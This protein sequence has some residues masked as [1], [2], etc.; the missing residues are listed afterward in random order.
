MHQCRKR[1]PHVISRWGVSYL[2]RGLRFSL[3]QAANTS[4]A[5][6]AHLNDQSTDRTLLG[7]PGAAG[8]GYR[9][10][11]P[12]PGT[13]RTIGDGRSRGSFDYVPDRHRSPGR[14]QGVR[15]F[16]ACWCW[17]PGAPTTTAATAMSVYRPKRAMH[18][19][20]NESSDCQIRSSTPMPG[21]CPIPPAQRLK[22]GLL[23]VDRAFGTQ[24]CAGLVWS[25]RIVHQS[26]I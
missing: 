19:H 16:V 14:S 15:F 4:G 11:L 5:G 2:R 6:A 26:V 22:C 7:A 1:D 23:C 12:G 21:R 8:T 17:R 18:R 3:C 24:C 20:Y 13:G 9:E 10:Q 25:L